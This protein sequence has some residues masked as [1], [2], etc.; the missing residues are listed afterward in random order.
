MT[1]PA[2]SCQGLLHP[3]TWLVH[4]CSLFFLEGTIGKTAFYNKRH[5]KITKTSVFLGLENDKGAS[6]EGGT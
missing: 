1:T 3:S 6:S 4:H 5:R 2:A